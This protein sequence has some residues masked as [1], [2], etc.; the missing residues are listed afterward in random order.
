MR[1]DLRPVSP[2]RSYR[3]AHRLRTVTGE[4][5]F[6]VVCQ[7]LGP[8]AL[9][10]EGLAARRATGMK[11]R[12]ADVDV[13][14][15]GHDALVQQRGLDR[16][17]LALQ[18]GGQVGAVEAVAQGLRAQTLQQLVCRYPV[19][20]DQVHHAET[21][22][23]VEADLVAQVGLEDDV[24]VLLQRPARVLAGLLDHHPAR[25]SQMADQ[26]LFV[27]QVRQNVFRPPRDRGDPAPGQPL[28]EILRQGKAQRLAALFHAVQ[29]AALQF[30][31]QSAHHGFD[32]GQLR[33]SSLRRSDEVET[34]PGWF[35]ATRDASLQQGRQGREKKQRPMLP[36]RLA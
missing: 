14:K 8:A 4:P 30:R 18:R 20:R 19:C 13:A 11:E 32:F 12:L 36:A 35:T 31:P 27:I 5:Q 28:G 15:T 16:R 23:I 34:L 29:A 9:N 25:H 6:C 1:E 10:R 7:F 2:A 33:H 22:G 24:I 26:D 17:A 21:A 3:V